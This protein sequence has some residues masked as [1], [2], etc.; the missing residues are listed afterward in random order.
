MISVID[1]PRAYRD[2]GLELESDIISIIIPGQTII[3]LN[4][5]AAVDEL[6]GRLG[7]NTGMV[8]YGERWRSQRKMT[9]EV[10]HK[11]AS[12]ERWPL[13]E[14]QS[15]LTLHRILNNPEGFS[16]EIR[17]MAGSTLLMAVYGYEVTSPDDSLVK[18]VEDAVEGFSQAVIVSN[19]FVNTV[20]W[21]QY[22]PEWFPGSVVEGESQ[23]LALSKRSDVGYPL[24]MDEESNGAAGTATPSMLSF[25][26]TRYVYQEA[27]SN[28]AEVEDRVRWA[29][30]ELTTAAVFKSVAST[31]VFVMA[32]AMHPDVQAKAQAELDAVIGTRL[33]EMADRDSLP[34]IRR[35]VKEVF[36]W[37]MV[38]PL[39]LPHA[40]I[41]DDTYKG[42]HIPKGAIVAI[43]NNPDVYIDPDRFNP[44]RFLDLS[45]PDAPTFGYGR[46]SCPGS[47]HAEASLFIVAAGLLACSTSALRKTQRKADPVEAGDEIKRGCSLHPFKCRITPRSERHEQIIRDWADRSRV[48]GDLWQTTMDYQNRVGS[49]FGGGGVAGASEANVDRRERLR[50]ACDPYILRNHL[51]SLECRLCLTLHTNEG[52]YL[53]HTQG[54]KHQTNLARRA[55]RDA[56]E[57]QLITAPAPAASVPRKM[58]IKIG[59][60][61]YRVTKVRDPL[62]AAAA[63]GGGAK[64]GM[65]VQV[66]L[67]QIKEGVIPRRRFMSAWEQKKEQPNRAYQYL[68]VAAEP[69]ESIAFRIPAREIEDIEENPDWNWSHWDA[70]TKTIQLPI[71]VQNIIFGAVRPIDILGQ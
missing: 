6:L 50:K 8:R 53:A 67:P 4:S 13:V 34:Y 17:R 46:R 1:E 15:R 33:P 23:R 60:P 38:L 59:R 69:Y 3:V 64:E 70:D 18:V 24:R 68:I 28:L 52:S 66:H 21:L 44:D 22:L 39:A 12:E 2:W 37:R 14:R 20:P 48:T 7:N 63:G 42:Y 58:F 11:I 62:M 47:H 32:M 61:G 30:G 29:A 71:H 5:Q 26:L 45:V 9:H 10:L 25:W 19:Y 36:R 55:A 16:A 35:I 65:M 27:P 56:K 54:K 43:S 57:T 51:G 31:R 41:Q 49:K 40:C